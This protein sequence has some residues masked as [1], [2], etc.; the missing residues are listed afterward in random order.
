MFSI[1]IKTN[2]MNSTTPSINKPSSSSSTTTNTTISTPTTIEKKIIWS[3]GKKLQQN[4]N[5]NVVKIAPNFYPFEM[6]FDRF[7]DDDDDD[8]KEIGA[9][10]PTNLNSTNTT[11][12]TTVKNVL[13][14]VIKH[15]NHENKNSNPYRLLSEVLAKEEDVDFK[16]Q[17]LQMDGTTPKSA[18]ISTVSSPQSE[19]IPEFLFGMTPHNDRSALSAS[20]TPASNTKTNASAL[21][22]WCLSGGPPNFSVA[23]NS[24]S[25]SFS[26]PSKRNKRT[27]A[28]LEENV[29]AAFSSQKIKRQSLP[30]EKNEEAILLNKIKEETEKAKQF[31]E[32]LAKLL[33][34][35]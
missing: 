35:S 3:S 19:P 33:K 11:E 12:T 30:T 2:S 25:S 6:L 16:S 14:Q 23:G 5:N 22:W 13:D 21:T 10:G 32:H 31:Q 1:V 18:A 29:A 17:F 20:S 7:N 15:R 9:K 26:E 28:S 34:E 24:S 27:I 8:E 4:A